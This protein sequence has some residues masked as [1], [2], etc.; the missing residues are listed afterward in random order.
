MDIN[1]F[2]LNYL[3]YFFYT[4][5]ENGFTRAAL[6]LNVAQPVVS[7]AVANLESQLGIKLLDRGTRH[8]KLTDQGQI[9]YADCQQIFETLDNVATKLS[10]DRSL[11]G[12]IKFS[13]TD[14]IAA[15]WI[16]PILKKLRG[17]HENL[18]PYVFTSQG[19]EALNLIRDGQLEFGL[20]F[21]V[22][23]LYS[24]F[25]VHDL[26][27]VPFDLVVG[28]RFQKVPNVLE[29]FI[30]SREV[31]FLGAKRFPVLEKLRKKYPKASIKLSS[32]SLRLHREWVLQGLGVS[33]L[34][35]FLVKDDLKTKRM[36]RIGQESFSFTLKLVTKRGRILSPAGKYLLKM[37]EEELAPS[38]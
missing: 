30:G 12:E 21:Y 25:S 19:S 20:F 6:K 5:R 36:V 24:D 37:I 8:L 35:S 17:E 27:S 22:P 26:S 16:T 15:E 14:I 31:D 38:R 32:N 18:H 29:S 1:K 7:R 2:E 3:K 28:N 4:V 11:R 23:E 13:C 10:A 9:L 34:P 33:I